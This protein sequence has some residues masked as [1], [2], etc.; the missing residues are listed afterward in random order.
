[1][2]EYC[3]SVLY[4]GNMVLNQYIQI[5]RKNLTYIKET[6]IFGTSREVSIPLK[7]IRKISLDNKILGCNLKI[8]YCY[9][10]NYEEVVVATGFS[11]E[12][13]QEIKS[14]VL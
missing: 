11:K 6:S 7:Y 10:L 4:G 14:L 5:D 13:G 3:S 12:D 2:F 1:M 9:P 8:H